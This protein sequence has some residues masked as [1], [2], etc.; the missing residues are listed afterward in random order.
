LS[1]K[2]KNITTHRVCFRVLRVEA[3]RLLDPLESL[4]AETACRIEVS[5]LR[6]APAGC[7]HRPP[8][9]I[10]ERNSYLVNARRLF[11][12]AA[13]AQCLAQSEKRVVQGWIEL[14]GTP[15]RRLRRCYI[16]M[17]QQQFGACDICLRQVVIE[18][19]RLGDKAFDV[20]EG[21]VGPASR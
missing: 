3:D 14:D 6:V 12:P 1:K 21:Y 17:P 11:E 2:P 7:V 8:G 19:Q 10:V 16:Q 4:A 13:A 20:F 15:R 5:H 18:L 9:L